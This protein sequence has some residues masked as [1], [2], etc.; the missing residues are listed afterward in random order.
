MSF[1]TCHCLSL[2]KLH[3]LEREVKRR[4]KREEKERKKRG[5]REEK[6][7]KKRGAAVQLNVSR[8]FL[9]F[10]AHTG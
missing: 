1:I 5:K 8:Q 2:I 4:E 10:S 7:R 3:R 9:W 6:E